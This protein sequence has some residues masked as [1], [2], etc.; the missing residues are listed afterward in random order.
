MEGKLHRTPTIAQRPNQSQPIG[1]GERS[2]KHG[3]CRVSAYRADQSG[4]SRPPM[5]RRD[6]AR[7]SRAQPS[8]AARS[9]ARTLS[10]S[11]TNTHTHSLSVACISMQSQPNE[12]PSPPPPPKGHS[13]SFIWRMR[14]V[15]LAFPRSAS[16]SLT[17]SHRAVCA[18]RDCAAASAAASAGRLPRAK[19]TGGMSHRSAVQ[20]N[21]CPTTVRFVAV[22]P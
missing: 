8:P 3:S 13:F 16:R 10:V 6:S 11:F 15:H 17:L 5:C 18:R 4:R 21:L 7:R 2:T 1:R 12:N 19:D 22:K 9:L 14:G 20:F